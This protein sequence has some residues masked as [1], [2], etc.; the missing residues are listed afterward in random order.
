VIAVGQAYMVPGGE[1]P[2]KLG[3]ARDQIHHAKAADRAANEVIGHNRV[4]DGPR[5]GKVVLIPERG[6][7]HDDE[8]QPNLEEERDE[9]QS[10]EQGVILV[11]GARRAD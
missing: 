11:P 5:V 6:P 4:H 1:D 7:R 2:A 10:A 3:K 8:E 9:D